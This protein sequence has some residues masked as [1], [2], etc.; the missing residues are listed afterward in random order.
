MLSHFGSLPQILLTMQTGTKKQPRIAKM[1]DLGR[2]PVCMSS[3][4][5]SGAIYSIKS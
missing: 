4:F 2:N 3:P 5:T 1:A